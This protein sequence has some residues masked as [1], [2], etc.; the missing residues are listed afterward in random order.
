[1]DLLR[2]LGRRGLAGADGPHRLVRDDE[3]GGILRR[4]ALET[5][6]KLAAD[7]FVDE[8]SLTL[9][10][11]LANAHHAG[12]TRLD[13]SRRALVDGLVRL[14]EIL[15]ALAVTGDDVGRAR[16]DDHAR[17][18]LAGERAVVLPV[19]VLG[20]DADLGAL[21]RGNGLEDVDRRRAAH[22]LDL[23]RIGRRRLGDRLHESR[24]LRRLHVHLPVARDDFL[25]AHFFS[26]LNFRCFT[27]A[28]LKTSLTVSR[29]AYS[30]E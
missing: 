11:R 28:C 17:G 20:A 19:A 12:E 29:N 7:D 2:L 23:V 16:V 18:D 8:V 5:N 22:D 4:Q 24:G 30:P 26:P 15:T 3:L 21:R 6:L 27:P 10:E 13:R 25:P 9:V 14:A 1:M